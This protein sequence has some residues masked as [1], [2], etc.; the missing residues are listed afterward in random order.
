MNALVAA[1]VAALTIAGDCSEEPGE[2]EFTCALGM[3]C[4]KLVVAPSGQ[5]PA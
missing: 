4:G 1:V 3:L 5:V 2:Y